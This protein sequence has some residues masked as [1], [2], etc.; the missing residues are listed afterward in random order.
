M[1]ADGSFFLKNLGKSSVSVNGV[2]IASGQLLNLSTNCLIEV[3]PQK[4]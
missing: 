1:E 3:I 4:Y 2:E